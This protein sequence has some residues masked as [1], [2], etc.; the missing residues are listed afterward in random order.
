LNDNNPQLLAVAKNAA[1]TIDAIYQ[2]LD[3]VQ[4]AGGATSLSGVASCHAMLESLNKNRA[5]VDNLV[6]KPLREAI[7][8][9]EKE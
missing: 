9:A 8:E 5:R 6:M 7:A 1:A 2:W 4:A 3:R